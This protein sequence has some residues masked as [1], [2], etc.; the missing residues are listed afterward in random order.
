M[1]ERTHGK[2]VVVSGPSGVGKS[3]ICR[4]LV[5]RT[6]AQLSV[7][8]TTRP[9]AAAEV[10]G[11]DYCFVTRETFEQGI[12]DDEFLEYAEVFGNYYGTPQAPVEAALKEG[13]TVILEIDVQGARKVKRLYPDVI[14]IFILP[15]TQKDLA[16]R[17]HGRGRGEDRKTAKMRLETAAGEIAAAWQYYEHMVINADLEQAIR[18]VIDIIQSKTGETQ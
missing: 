18:E 11:R 4:A 10:D 6:G 1:I 13:K 14:M 17:M 8:T 2:L 12:R 15:P 5:E 16:S 3:T 7:S 9:R